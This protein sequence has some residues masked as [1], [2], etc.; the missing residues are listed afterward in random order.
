MP[1]PT[2]PGGLHAAFVAAFN[3]GDVAG[4][5]ELYEP[6]SAF[7]TAPGQVAK[8][9]DAIRDAVLGL[10]AYRGKVQ[11]NTRWVTV[12]GDIALL[13]GEWNLHGTNPADGSPA[14]IEALDTEVA[15]RGA[16]GAWRFVIDDPFGNVKPGA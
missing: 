2:T 5:M 6:D 3:A 4:L 8:G 14:V 9:L 10:L 1:A 12:V 13:H 15:R 16:D 7:V 11:I